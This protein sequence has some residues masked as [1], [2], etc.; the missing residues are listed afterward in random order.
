MDETYVKIGGQW[1]YLYRGLA[2]VQF[3]PASFLSESPPHKNH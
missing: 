1:K 2:F 3:K